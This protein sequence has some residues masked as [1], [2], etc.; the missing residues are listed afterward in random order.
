[1]EIKLLTGIWRRS[2]LKIN[3]NQLNFLLLLVIIPIVV[4]QI[5]LFHVTSSHKFIILSGNFN[6]LRYC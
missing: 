4:L 6:L 5:N 2:P 3:Q 1:M